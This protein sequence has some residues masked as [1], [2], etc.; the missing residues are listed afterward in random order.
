[1]F[2]TIG[3]FGTEVELLAD[4]VVS[5]VSDVSVVL[6][7]AMEMVLSP[8]EIRE[9]FRALRDEGGASAPTAHHLLP[10]PYNEESK[11]AL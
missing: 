9:T 5:N 1:M 10:R 8:L 6:V 2:E 4:R 7:V 3:T 11:Q